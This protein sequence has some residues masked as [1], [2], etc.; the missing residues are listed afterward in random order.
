MTVLPHAAASPS[1]LVQLARVVGAHAVSA[2]ETDRFAYSRDCWP[3]DLVQMRSGLVPS[4]PACIVWPETPEEVSRVFALAAELGIPIVPYGAGSGV[5]GGA[6]PIDGGITVDFKRMR[7]I[8]ELDETNL[9]VEVEA[10]I[11]GERL[12]HRLNQRGY[13]LGHFP[14]SIVCSTLG[15]WLAARSA[16]QTSTMYGKIED[17]TMGLEVVSPGMVRQMTTGPRPGL[18]PNFN[19]LMLGS[20]GTFGAITAARLR[21]HPNPEAR[22]MRGFRFPNVE[23]G[24]DAIRL[25]LRAGLRPAVVRLYDALDTFIGRGHS[26][27]KPDSEASWSADA[28]SKKLKDR[29]GDIGLGR[30]PF[31]QKLAKAMVKKTVSAVLGSPIL[32]NK[33]V[34]ALPEQCMLILGF[35]GQTALINAEY[36][37]AKEVCLQQG[38]QDLG[39]GP[40]E[41]WLANR[42]NVSFKQ[43]KAYASG[44]FT[45][46]MEVA[47]NWERLLPLY[48]NVRRAIGRDAFVMAHFSHAYLEGCS[49]YFTFAGA[50]GDAMNPD[51][52]LERYD[53]I[54]TNAMAAVHE[55]G[56]TVSH[57]HGVGILKAEAMAKEHGAGGKELLD[58][59]KYGFD[60]R[61]I[62][63]TGKLGLRTK[64]LQRTASSVNVNRVGGEIPDEIQA[65]VGV[66]NIVK[67][68]G[69]TSIRPADES[70][71]AAVLRLAFARRIAVASDQTGFRSPARAM[72]ID[73][74]HF[75]GITRLSKRSLFVEVET[76]L[77]VHQLESTL[78]K[79]GLSLGHLHPRCLGRSVGASLAFNTLIRRST[80]HGDLDK[81]CF[82]VRSL[83]SDGTVVE[84]RPVPRSATGPELDRA[85]IGSAGRWGIMTR[86][87]LRIVEAPKFIRTLGFKC[88]DKKT[89]I[90]LGRRIYRNGINAGAARCF[91]EDGV[92]LVLSFFAQEEKLVEATHK[93]AVSVGAE[94]DVRP[95]TATEHEATGGRFDAVVEIGV[96]WNVAEEAWETVQSLNIEEAWLDFMTPQGLT[97]VARVSGREARKNVVAFAQGE[98]F[99]VLA[100]ARQFE[101]LERA[102][103]D[104]PPRGDYED[105]A[106]RISSFIDQYGMFRGR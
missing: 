10:G 41:H 95:Y 48:K 58:A 104:S 91:V 16:G 74:S 77:V 45:D 39:E 27:D 57:H 19:A 62:L 61:G 49:I 102:S 11:I 4:S 82:A 106:I 37:V 96:P 20:E 68:G 52:I 12:E 99:P 26:K 85:F 38:A 97:L 54:W 80:A 24:L 46:T 83:L 87:V 94:L 73:L 79:Q 3:R 32:L 33:A 9:Q 29:L 31:G 89:A 40:G 75:S 63:N 25:I 5:C 28:I 103:P 1:L 65:A 13:T 51:A 8:R 7:A 98:G 67:K 69:R 36:V 86:A 81:V 15:G 64:S 92:H 59:L 72:H 53:R 76:G 47:A 60:P 14:S 105:V 22:V 34:D 56:G 78:R 23:A 50:G 88:G 84:T 71:L 35:E 42:H 70:A 2:L 66:A 100:G 90:E 43:S 17:M 18:A 44:L 101:S 21:I 55:S 93:L 6:R 30:N